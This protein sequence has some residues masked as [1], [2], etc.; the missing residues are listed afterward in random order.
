MPL[1]VGQLLSLMSSLTLSS[2]LLSVHHCWSVCWLSVLKRGVIETKSAIYVIN[3]LPQSVITRSGV[4]LNAS[5]S[6][7]SHP[8]IILKK[9]NLE[10]YQCPHES[11][12]FNARLLS[13]FRDQL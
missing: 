1:T 2:L 6:H 12:L 3:P 5:L 11:K 13:D 10:E 8:H 9:E 7:S 4:W